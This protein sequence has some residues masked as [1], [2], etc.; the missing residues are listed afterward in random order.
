MKTITIQGHTIVTNHITAISRLTY[1]CN[2]RLGIAFLE[3]K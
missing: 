3:Q 2:H 1:L